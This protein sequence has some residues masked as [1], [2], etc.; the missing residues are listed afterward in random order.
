MNDF[1]KEIKF[2][3]CL[4]FTISRLFRVVNKFAEESFADIDICP[5]HGYLMI[6][7]DEKREGL[8]VNEISENLTIAASTVTRFVDKL[9]EKGYVEREKQGKKSFTRITDVGIEKMPDVYIAWRKI[10]DKFEAAI[11]DGDYLKDTTAS[12]KKFTER[13]ENKIVKEIKKD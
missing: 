10:Y 8:S 1:E 5:T 6:L 13:L 12:M 7:L 3:S 2:K 11:A 4:F 9:I